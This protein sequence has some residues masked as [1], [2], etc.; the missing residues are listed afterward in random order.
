MEQKSDYAEADKVALTAANYIL[1]TLFQKNDL[2]RL[3]SLQFII[4][5]MSGSPDF[6]INIDASASKIAKGNDDLLGLYM[7][8]MSKFALENRGEA[9]DANKVK[10][11]AIR[12]LLTYC[13][14]EN[15]NMKMS[16][17]MRKLSEAN[18]NG[19]LEAAL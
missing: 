9:A 3:R 11:S 2:S 6:N 13:E 16:K 12:T 18:K 17:E 7:V 1:S 14:N 19:K 5:W 10:L 8:A 4:K 15:N